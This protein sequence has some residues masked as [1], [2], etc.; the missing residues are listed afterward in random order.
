MISITRY[1]KIS[2]FPSQVISKSKVKIHL[3]PTMDILFHAILYFYILSV[4][5]FHRPI[6]VH[7]YTMK[8]DTSCA[9]KKYIHKLPS[10]VLKCSHIL[11]ELC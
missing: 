3:F 1:L 10:I 5:L 2:R 7:I 11:H 6:Y 9:F 4:I 8:S